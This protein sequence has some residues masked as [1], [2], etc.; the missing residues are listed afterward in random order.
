MGLFYITN[1]RM[2]LYW[3]ALDI[4]SLN[5]N[6]YSNR[7]KTGMYLFLLLTLKYVLKRECKEYLD[8]SYKNIEKRASNVKYVSV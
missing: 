6:N 8:N 1:I 4:F 7:T 5:T 3:Y 2:Y